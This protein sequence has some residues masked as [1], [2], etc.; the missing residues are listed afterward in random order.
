[1]SRLLGGGLLAAIAVVGIAPWARL[2]MP[3]EAQA[4]PPQAAPED[5]RPHVEV[6]HP[7]RKTL[8]R[9]LKVAGEVRPNQE[10]GIFARVPGY[11][12]S[13][14]V[15]R[16]ARVK[17]GDL[18]VKIA[19]PELEKQLAREQAELAL[20]PPSIKKAR[21][22][23]DARK[24]IFQRLAA[25]AAK[26]ADLVNRDALDDAEG[27]CRAAEAEVELAEARTKTFETAIEKTRTM[28]EF[29]TIRAPFDGVITERWVDPGFLV[30]AGTTKML[31]L[32]QADVVRTRVHVPQSD[33]V[34]MRDDST[35]EIAIEELPGRTFTSKVSRLFWGLNRE[36]KTMAVEIDVRN[37]GADQNRWVR[38]GM[39]ARV[40]LN[41]DPRPNALVLP[42]SA[43]VVEKKKTFVFVVRDGVAK[44][45]AVDIAFDNGVEFEVRSGVGDG[46]DVV[47]AG[48]NLIS[49]SDRV[50]ASRRDSR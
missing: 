7:Q 41:L 10:T 8:F 32:V 14:P 40:T 47:V 45:V 34:S 29:A 25:V 28:I 1:M 9:R 39:Y 15:D 49:D 27:R 46:D 23:C 36:T 24:A 43:L 6:A 4:A 48:K 3:G 18:L 22:E 12:E 31:H 33:V 44:K 20:C 19:V 26:T 35:A 13:V 17:Q 5:R 2:W 37:E 38:P 21:A 11:V 16:G 42:A 50:R 30:Q